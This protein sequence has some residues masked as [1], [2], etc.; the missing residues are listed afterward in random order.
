MGSITKHGS[1]SVQYRV[2]SRKDLAIIID[3]FDKYPSITQKRAD[4]ELFKQG[5]ERIKADKHLTRDGLNEFVAIKASRN[6]GLSE[7]LKVAFSDITPIPRPVVINSNIP[8][9]Q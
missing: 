9:P 7:K 6:L 8:D 2:Q 4:F 3:H 1:E 5:Y